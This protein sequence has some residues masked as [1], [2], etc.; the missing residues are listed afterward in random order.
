MKEELNQY[1]LENLSPDAKWVKE[2][3]EQ[4]DKEFIPIMDKVS[5]NF[6]MQLIRMTRPKRILEIGTAIGY[7]S[8]Q[9]VEAYPDTKIVTIERDTY[10][11]EQAVKYINQYEKQ[12]NIKVIH[13]D[14][15]DVLA[16]LRREA[17]FDL[18][19]IDAA[20]GQYQ[21]FFELASPLLSAQGIIISDNVLF[22]G[23]VV[24]ST[25]VKPKFLKIVNKI[26]AYNQWLMHHPDYV[27]S[28]VPIG[29]GVAIS[30]KK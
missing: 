8:L 30:Y 23:Y 27:T 24:N 20:K 18:I 21:H 22:K 15:L 5:I 11:Y 17:A 16:N 2:M 26:R 13:G 7:S 19:F 4:A 28:I 25:D 9:M 12:A 1:L 14:A 6:L 29:D 10:R 3:E